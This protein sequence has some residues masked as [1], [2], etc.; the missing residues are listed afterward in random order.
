LG[1]VD[2]NRPGML[3][4][5]A[6]LIS[7]AGANILRVVN[8]TMDDGSFDITFVAHGLTAGQE[9]ELTDAFQTHSGE[10][11]YLEIV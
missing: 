2:A 7:I 6:S 11:R 1:K 3:A 9:K 4:M 10:L 5:F 8:D